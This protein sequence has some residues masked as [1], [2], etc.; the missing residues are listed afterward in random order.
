MYSLAKS[1]H[2]SV[3]DGRISVF[4]QIY[5]RLRLRSW[6][7]ESDT[8]NY[9]VRNCWH[10]RKKFGMRVNSFLLKPTFY[11]MW[12]SSPPAE[13]Q[14]HRLRHRAESRSPWED[15]LQIKRTQRVINH[16]MVPSIR[17]AVDA[18]QYHITDSD[19]RHYS[20]VRCSDFPSEWWCTGCAAGIAMPWRIRI[21]DWRADK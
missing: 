18:V 15:T 16:P 20:E 14:C 11:P 21:D 9:L 10:G 19:L 5:R 17:P 2:G 13:L 1:S 6:S 3:S 4:K 8:D 7:S 12:S